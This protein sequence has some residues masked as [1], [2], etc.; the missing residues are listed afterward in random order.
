MNRQTLVFVEVRYRKTALYV[1]TVASVTAKTQ[2]KTHLTAKHY[3]QKDKHGNGMPCRLDV[4]GIE[5][6]DH[7]LNYL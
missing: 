4:V 7:K 3:L 1:Y 5:L 2:A 6:S